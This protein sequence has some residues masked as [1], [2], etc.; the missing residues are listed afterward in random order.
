FDQHPPPRLTRLALNPSEASAGRSRDLNPPQRNATARCL[1]WAAGLFICGIVFQPRRGS[2]QA[3]VDASHVLHALCFKP[4]LKRIR[5]TTD[6]HAHAI[7]PRRASTEDAAKM[8]ACFRGQGEG[9]I[10]RAITN[11]SREKQERLVSCRRGISKKL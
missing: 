4:F 9:F 8:H 1:G 7:L 3:F 10:E 6:E 5:S 2:F 11:S